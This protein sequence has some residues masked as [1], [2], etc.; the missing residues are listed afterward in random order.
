MG[1][2]AKVSTRKFSATYNL[3]K[4]VATKSIDPK[5]HFLDKCENCHKEFHYTGDYIREGVIICPHC[6]YQ[7]QFFPGNYDW[8][9]TDFENE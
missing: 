1:R 9:E 7:M 2:H 8:V 4:G 6:G 5:Y 3:F